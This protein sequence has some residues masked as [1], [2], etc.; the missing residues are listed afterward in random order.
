[1]KTFTVQCDKAGFFEQYHKFRDIMTS[2]E[3]T[4]A[5]K[6]AAYKGFC[7]YYFGFEGSPEDTEIITNAFLSLTDEWN[8]R[9][10]Y[11]FIHKLHNTLL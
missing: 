10:S 9:Q 5:Q 4:A 1:M 6:D 8:T 11:E 7:L 3:Y 2:T